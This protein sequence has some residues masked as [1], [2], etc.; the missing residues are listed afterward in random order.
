MPHEN[1]QLAQAPNGELGPRCKECGL[2]LTFGSAMVID[3][4]YFC[5]DCYV[6]ITGAE[7]STTVGEAEQGFWMAESK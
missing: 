6:K 4:N 3:N 5:W 1:I 7:S 2:R